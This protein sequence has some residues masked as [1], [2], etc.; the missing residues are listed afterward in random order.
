V[1]VAVIL[2]AVAGPTQAV[3]SSIVRGCYN[4]R[5]GGESTQGNLRILRAGRSCPSAATTIS[6]NAA[7]PR[8]VTGAIGAAGVAG[9]TGPKGATGSTGA[10]GAKGETGAAGA[11]GEIGAT[12]ATGPATGPA[13]GALTA[14]YPNPE[15]KVSGGDNG[16]SGCKNGEA[17]VG[18]SPLAALT[19]A[20]GVFSDVNAN[21]AVGRE[22]LT[23]NTGHQNS[24]FGLRALRANTDGERNSAFGSSALPSNT[25]G[26]GNSAF[27]A[28]A[29]AANV[30]GSAN[31][32]FGEHAL[33]A[34]TGNGNSAL[35]QMAL[36]SNTSGAGNSALGASALLDNTT[37]AENTAVGIFAGELLG[38]GTQDTLLGYQAGSNLESSESS[39]IE[40]GNP[41]TKGESNVIRI[42]GVNGTLSGQQNK[43]FIPAAE[44][45]IAGG[46]ALDINGEGQIGEAP[47]SRRF[48]TGIR[49]LGASIEGLLA[50]RPVSFHYKPAYIRGQ[51]DPL[52]FGL[53]AEE[54][55]KV[56]PNLVVHGGDGKPY[57]VAY[58]ELPVLL[59]ALAQREHWRIEDQQRQLDAQRREL[60]S[61]RRE[62]AALLGQQRQIAGLAKEVGALQRE[63]TR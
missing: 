34:N 23:S 61:Q 1:I 27:G 55:A 47:S 52:E 59:L 14:S 18:L 9:A 43:L 7:G 15:L 51:P 19:C 24:A 6:W 29:L 22:T 46:V 11:K 44:S 41:G 36:T 20:P 28:G 21:T 56:Y 38:T 5:T 12:G 48:K 16:A 62:I 39:D 3:G 13:G 33:S 35:G 60:A 4:A 26:L 63:P 2:G 30:A 58:Q 40:I 31:A 53:I 17:L 8:G 57:A 49:P 10:T 54:V 42:G 32:A 50:L 45:T 25:S 37:G